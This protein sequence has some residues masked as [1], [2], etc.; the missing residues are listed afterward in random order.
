MVDNPYITLIRCITVMY[1]V[2]KLPGNWDD[3]KR[4]VK[5]T[6]TYIEMPTTTLGV[7]SIGMSISNL[8]SMIEWMLDVEGGVDFDKDDILSRVRLNVKD[9]TFYSHELQLSLAVES[10]EERSKKE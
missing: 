10:D 1:L 7:D 4:V 6:I 2:N 8:R 3:T 5:E 9:D